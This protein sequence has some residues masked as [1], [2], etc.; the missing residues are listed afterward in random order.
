MFL[1]INKNSSIFFTYILSF[2]IFGNIKN[3]KIEYD[4]DYFLQKIPSQKDKSITVLK[5]DAS[6]GEGLNELIEYLYQN[7]QFNEVKEKNTI[8]NEEKKE[9]EELNKDN[10]YYAIRMFGLNDSG[11]TKILY[12]LAVDEDVVTIPT[13]GFNVETIK[14]ENYE[15]DLQIYDLFLFILMK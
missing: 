7:S 6:T 10:N 2:I 3:N 1:C 4:P 8:E 13:M 5:G 15:K 9:K 11:K 14:F 12:K